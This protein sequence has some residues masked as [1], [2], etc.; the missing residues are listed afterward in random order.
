MMF[1][2]NRPQTWRIKHKQDHEVV[3]QTR[4]RKYRANATKKQQRPVNY[5]TKY[6]GQAQF[7]PRVCGAAFCAN[8]V[9][10]EEL[11]DKRDHVFFLKLALGLR[12]DKCRFLPVRTGQSRAAFDLF[13]NPASPRYGSD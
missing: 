8:Q 13:Q 9:G 2:F 5:L 1:F 12:L 10:V 11:P 6:M 7:L 4:R 3:A